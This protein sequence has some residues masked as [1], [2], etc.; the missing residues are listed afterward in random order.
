[1]KIK[2]FD[3]PNIKEQHFLN[4]YEWETITHPKFPIPNIAFYHPQQSEH[5][6]KHLKNVMNPDESARANEVK[7]KH[8]AQCGTPLFIDAET[9]NTVCGFREKDVLEKWA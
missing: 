3:T 1:M 6:K 4:Y 9:G 8:Q 7:Q 5:F 2:V